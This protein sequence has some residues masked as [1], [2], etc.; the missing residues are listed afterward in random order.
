MLTYPLFWLIIFV[1]PL[2][3]SVAGVNLH[4]R[5]VRQIVY[6]VR[7][8]FSVLEGCGCK[9]SYVRSNLLQSPFITASPFNASSSSYCTQ[10]DLSP[11]GIA[12]YKRSHER[13]TD[14][15]SS[16]APFVVFSSLPNVLHSLDPS[17]LP[18]SLSLAHSRAYPPTVITTQRRGRYSRPK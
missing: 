9:E 14:R 15:P 2:S 8:G 6:F 16:R 7:R 18:F 17:P 11:S 10:N 4:L 12:T 13:S 1:E 3:L 5:V